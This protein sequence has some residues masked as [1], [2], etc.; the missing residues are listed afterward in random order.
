VDGEII[1]EKFNDSVIGRLVTEASVSSM[2]NDFLDSYLKD[3]ISMSYPSKN[4]LE[5]DVMF[6]ASC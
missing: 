5:H 1:L 4:P 3:F 2:R 6:I